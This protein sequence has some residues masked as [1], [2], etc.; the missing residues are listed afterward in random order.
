MR[1]LVKEKTTKGYGSIPPIKISEVEFFKENRFNI[2]LA[3]KD[4]D[5]KTILKVA[6]EIQARTFLKE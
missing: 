1:V 4:M 3:G 6:E 2:L 5:S